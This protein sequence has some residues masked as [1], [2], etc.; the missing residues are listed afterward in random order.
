V[1]GFSTDDGFSLGHR[2]LGK[3]GGGGRAISQMQQ[4]HSVKAAFCLVLRG[5]LNAIVKA[6]S[7][8]DAI[9]EVGRLGNFSSIFPG[10]SST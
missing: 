2:S 6:H 7:V 3:G 1:A 8:S 5:S 4:D 9:A 10:P